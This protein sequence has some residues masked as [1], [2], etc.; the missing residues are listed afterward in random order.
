MFTLTANSKKKSE[1][2]KTKARFDFNWTDKKKRRFKQKIVQA[3]L[4]L[5][6]ISR[7]KKGCT[8]S[9]ALSPRKASSQVLRSL[10]HTIT[11]RSQK[12]FHTSV[13][14]KLLLQNNTSHQKFHS[15]LKSIYKP[16]D[17]RHS[18]QK[19]K[20]RFQWLKPTENASQL[21][22]IPTA[23]VT[24]TPVQPNQGTTAES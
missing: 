4:F 24:L 13:V 19:R 6:G 16:T 12:P 8:S 18:R 15:K 10:P 21:K 23:I 3:V 7:K 2:Q 11:F 17:L 22:N 1:I 5:Q 9:N 20:Q 14:A